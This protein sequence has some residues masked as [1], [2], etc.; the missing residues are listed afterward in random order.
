MTVQ[1]LIEALSKIKDK[2]KRVGVYNYEYSVYEPVNDVSCLSK[3][4]ILDV[5]CED[6][7]D[8]DG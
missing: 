4:I 5:D 3:I 6:T 8:L 2:S 1:E 7:L